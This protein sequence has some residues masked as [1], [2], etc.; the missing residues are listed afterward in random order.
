MT[1]GCTSILKLNNTTT[2][3]KNI[4][5]MSMTAIVFNNTLITCNTTPINILFL[6]LCIGEQT[7]K[8]CL[9]VETF[10]IESY[11]MD[12]SPN[13]WSVPQS[14][15]SLNLECFELGFNIEWW[16]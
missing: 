5:L 1:A 4:Q 6:Y 3:I 16:V 12:I 7:R 8:R 13:L 15:A 9:F 10:N 2:Y 11:V 14:N